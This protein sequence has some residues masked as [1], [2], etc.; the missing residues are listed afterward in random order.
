M[1][2]KAFVLSVHP[3]MEA[4]YQRRHNPAWG[5]LL[6][7]LKEHGARNYSIFLHPQTRQLFGYVEIENEAHWNA[8]ANTPICRRWW[9][10]MADIMPAN[11]DHSP[12]STPL[13][14][15]FHLA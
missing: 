5:E 12:V 11:S 9:K 13:K 3:G 14:E 1:I 6:D 15:V 8:L 7:A 2:R 4:E 10:Y